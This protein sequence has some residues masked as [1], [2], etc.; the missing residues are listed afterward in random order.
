MNALRHCVLRISNFKLYIY[1][2]MYVAKA[3]ATLVTSCCFVTGSLQQS[4]YRFYSTSLHSHPLQYIPI[5]PSAP[6]NIPT[7]VH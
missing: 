2:P 6:G 3:L 1:E 4:C 5:C 7:K